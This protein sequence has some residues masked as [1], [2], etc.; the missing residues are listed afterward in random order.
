MP[1]LSYLIDLLCANYLHS[2]SYGAHIELCFALCITF[3]MVSF[4]RTIS[5]T[6]TTT[7][8]A[9]LTSLLKGYATGGSSLSS[10][11]GTTCL[12]GLFPNGTSC[13]LCPSGQACSGQLIS[14]C[15]ANTYSPAGSAFCLPCAPGYVSGA[16]ASVCVP[17][18]GGTYAS[19]GASCLQCLAGTQD[20]FSFFVLLHLS[21][22]TWFRFMALLSSPYTTSPI[23][24]HNRYIL[25]HRS[26]CMHLLC[27]R[28]FLEQWFIYLH[29][30]RQVT[31]LVST[32][33]YIPL[34]PVSYATGDSSVSP[35]TYTPTLRSTL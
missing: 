6:L 3:L 18:A 12:P 13:Q 34:L 1:L 29:Y 22:F 14:M 9:S 32:H 23:P 30:M 2:C 28:L 8:G 19:P 10:S 31:P 16:L 25:K 15:P 21:I 35:A 20:S 4:S 11:S 7:V 27:I 24:P 33:S 5:S 26:D 17:C